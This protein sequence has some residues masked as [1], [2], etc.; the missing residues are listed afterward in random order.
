M[1]SWYQK[2]ASGWHINSKKRKRE[3]SNSFS[4]FASGK[5]LTPDLPFMMGQ[6]LE[7]NNMKMGFHQSRRDV[8]NVEKT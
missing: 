1:Y 6:A 3:I 8:M 5:T 2:P 4:F 7:G